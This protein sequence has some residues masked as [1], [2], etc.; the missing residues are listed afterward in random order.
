MSRLSIVIIDDHA[1]LRAG[2]R[3]LIEAQPEM[4]VV[5][6]AGGLRAGL[7][8]VR[9][10]Q[11][12]VAVLDLSMPDSPG[13]AGIDRLREASPKTRV[14]VLT[15]HD[16]PAFVRGALARGASGYVS[17]ASADTRLIEAI[18]AVHEGKTFVEAAGRDAPA[19]APGTA[20]ATPRPPL[21]AMLD[22]LSDRERA[23]LADVARGR[24]SKEIAETTGLSIKTVESYRA[25]AM[26]KLDLRSRA[27]LVRIAIES[28]LLSEPPRA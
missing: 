4:R 17:K 2:L 23:V 14:L 22:T 27:D 28:G 15:M 8:L 18:L 26:H 10:H 6:E 9:E 1:V 5:G 20:E 13:L 21:A 25:R 24:T 7:E 19:L 3:M 16:D 12:N 11:P